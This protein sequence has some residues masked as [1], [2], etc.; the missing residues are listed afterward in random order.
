MDGRRKGAHQALTVVHSLHSSATSCNARQ[1]PHLWA[2]LLASAG[3]M[4][5]EGALPFTEGCER[6]WTAKNFAS[7][8]A[9]KMSKGFRTRRSLDNSIQGSERERATSSAFSR[10]YY[11]F[12]YI[13]PGEISS[14]IK[15]DIG[16]E[17]NDDERGDMAAHE[18]RHM[19]KRN[20]LKD[21]NVLMTR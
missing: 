20:Y 12:R 19:K 16:G 8:S 5:H 14:P 3:S 17:G 7:S 1:C 6:A 2:T 15:S 9:G 10:R 18:K 11:F 21:V 4:K 13:D